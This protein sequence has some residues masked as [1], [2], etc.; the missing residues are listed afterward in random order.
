MDQHRFCLTAITH[1]QELIEHSNKFGCIGIG[2]SMGFIVRLGGFPVFYVPSPDHT[3]DDDDRYKGISLLYRL[4]E[5][6][7]ILEAV[8]RRG[9]RSE[10]IDMENVLGAVKFLANICYPTDRLVEERG[11]A[12]NYYN[13][14]EWR[15][16]YGMVSEKADVL[17]KIDHY[18]VRAFENKPIIHFVEHIVVNVAE[19]G[20]IGGSVE[21]VQRVMQKLGLRDDILDV[22]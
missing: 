9:I 17:D 2:F 18:E 20:R 11:N 4:A 1:K 16:I 21:D 12:V 13:Q 22:I 19:L 10:D 14:R 8:I 5:T 3:S 7:E 15:I 6:Q